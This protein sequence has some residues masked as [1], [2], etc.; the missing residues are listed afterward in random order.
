[1]FDTVAL[2]VLAELLPNELVARVRPAVLAGER[3]LV[4]PGRLGSILPG[5]GLQR[6]SVVR[7]EGPIGTVMP[8]MPTV[9]PSRGVS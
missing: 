9:K 1:M 8:S 3:R 6:G 7:V 4:V 2:V 5:G